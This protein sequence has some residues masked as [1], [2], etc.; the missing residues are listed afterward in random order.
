MRHIFNCNGQLPKSLM[1][2]PRLELPSWAIS[3]QKDFFL[4]NKLRVERRALGYRQQQP[5]EQNKYKEVQGPP[6]SMAELEGFYKLQ[7]CRSISGKINQAGIT[8]ANPTP[9]IPAGKDAVHK[10]LGNYTS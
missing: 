10:P 8:E 7:R 3:H 4:G 1:L 5:L 9:V 6:G 2:A